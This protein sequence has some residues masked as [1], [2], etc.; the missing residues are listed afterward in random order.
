MDSEPKAKD[1]CTIQRATSAVVYEGAERESE[2][3]SEIE[4]LNA[5]A[6]C[7]RKQLLTGLVVWQKTHSASPLK[8]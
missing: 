6:T 2:R 7:N 1:A 8:S 5:N 4:K 3:V